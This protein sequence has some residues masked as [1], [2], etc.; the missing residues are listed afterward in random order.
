MIKKLR[1]IVIR[2][3]ILCNLDTSFYNGGIKDQNLKHK[4]GV[5]N[6]LSG[7]MLTISFHY[8]K[9]IFEFYLLNRLVIRSKLMTPIQNRIFKQ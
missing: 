3:Y 1:N 5:S 2:L 9:E 4:C 7:V 6:N 8:E